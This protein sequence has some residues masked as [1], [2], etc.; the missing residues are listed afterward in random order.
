MRIKTKNELAYN[1]GTVVDDKVDSQSIV[2]V[3]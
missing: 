3:K 1:V 2:L